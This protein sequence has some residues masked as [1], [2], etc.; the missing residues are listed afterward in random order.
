MLVSF[1]TQSPL[2]FI[3]I[4]V[5]Y[6]HAIHEDGVWNAVRRDFK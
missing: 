2:P 5:F 6:F 1:Q 4:L 3:L